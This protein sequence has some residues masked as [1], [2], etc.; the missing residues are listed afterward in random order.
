MKLSCLVLLDLSTFLCGV[1]SAGEDPNTFAGK[2]EMSGIALKDYEG[3][4][5]NW[6]F[7]TVRFRK[8]TNEMRLTYANDTAWEALSKHVAEFPKGSVF[9]KI[10]IATAEDPAFSSSAVPS[11]ARRYQF[12]VRDKEKFKTSDG[13]GYALFDPNGLTFP[14]NPARTTAACAACHHIVPERNYVFSDI[15]V[16][17]PFVLH[18][19][20]RLGGLS[21]RFEYSSLA[22]SSLPTEIQKILPKDVKKVRSLEGALRKDL[23]QGTLD[24]IRPILADEAVSSGQP[25][26]LLS[27]DA[28][29]YSIVIAGKGKCGSLLVALDGV[30]NV[31]FKSNEKFE[32]HFCHAAK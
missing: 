28:K 2:T 7:V 11:G 17:S 15:M 5:R 20:D 18:N 22:V 23:F 12:M 1:V 9:A 8:D 3:F 16:G 25:A 21:H 6:H 27:E 13:W 30:S 31:V 14:E 32:V 10:G 26:L 29:R 24:E 4:E 19:P